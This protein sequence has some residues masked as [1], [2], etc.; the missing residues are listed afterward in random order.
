MLRAA[1]NHR[2]MKGVWAGA[3]ED[4][5]CCWGCCFLLPRLKRGRAC[6]AGLVGVAA[7]TAGVVGAVT[8]AG[9]EEEPAGLMSG[10]I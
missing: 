4:C 1:A 7:C 6:N 5:C 10:F 3:A 9:L 8:G 2:L